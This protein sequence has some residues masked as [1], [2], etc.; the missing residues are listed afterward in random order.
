[1]TD[2]GSKVIFIQS[3]GLP[4]V[5]V[6]VDFF[7]GAAFD[8]ADKQGLARLTMQLLD[9]GTHQYDEFA[10]AERLATNGSQMSGNF[11]LDRSGVSLR[12]LSYDEPLTD[13]ISLLSEILS[14]PVFPAEVL[15]R[16]KEVSIISLRERNTRPS[17]I[18]AK[19]MSEAL[20]GEHP[21]RSTGIGTE[22]TIE[23]LA[24]SDLV[25]FHQRFYRA[26]NAVITIVGD[27]DEERARTIAENITN[28]LPKGSIE[29]EQLPDIMAITEV[30]ELIIPH[31]SA[32]A[33]IR[34]G[35]VGFRRGDPDH[36]PLVLANQI[37]GGGGMTSIL[38]DELRERRGMTYGVGSYFN[39]LKDPGAFVVAFQT[40]KDQAWEALDVTLNILRKFVES[41]PDAEQVERAKKYFVGAFA[42]NVDSNGEL[43][44][45]YSTINFYDLP[46]DY[47]DS[48]S[49][50]VEAVTLNQIRD[51][52][53]RRM[54]LDKVVRIIVGPEKPLTEPNG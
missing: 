29:R 51:A 10:I 54:S 38:Y 53:S 1:M 6:S 49:S 40:R 21:Y 33:H 48:F 3:L 28:G 47:I 7:A 41:G 23:S 24:R 2:S 18:A 16:E 39:P 14:N 27:L 19:L 15:N 32:Q 20:F 4:M 30:Q 5:D 50:R 31:D 34:I 52:I 8:P 17:S 25:G 22:E 37:L 42:L 35:M 11:D 26:S 46:L 43:L 13:S 12:S 45:Y 36:L 44:D 9:K